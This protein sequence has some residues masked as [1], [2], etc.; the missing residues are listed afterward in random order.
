MRVDWRHRVRVR[1]A[2][3]GSTRVRA[4]TT[5]YLE[6]RLVVG[7]SGRVEVDEAGAW[8]AHEID[9]IEPGSVICENCGSD[10]YRVERPAESS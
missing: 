8:V 5:G 10:R 1:C 3:C 2:G 7:E 9:R 6:G 4:I